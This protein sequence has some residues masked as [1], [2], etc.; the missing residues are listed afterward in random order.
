[1]RKDPTLL[2]EILEG[3]PLT[4][5]E[6]EILDLVARG[7]TSQQIADQLYLA[8]ETVRTYRKRI[9]AKLGA[10]TSSHAVAISIGRGLINIAD[11]MD[12]MD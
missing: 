12:E 1:M 6:L 4:E 10:Y 7:K 3:E 11:I 5:R 2:G 9:Y 8:L